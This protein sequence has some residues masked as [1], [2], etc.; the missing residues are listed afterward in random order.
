M[1]FSARFFAFFAN[2][3]VSDPVLGHIMPPKHVQ[4]PF[5]ARLSLSRH[6]PMSDCCGSISISPLWAHFHL[7]RNP[8]PDPE[9]PIDQ[10]PPVLQSAPKTITLPNR[11]QKGHRIRSARMGT[12]FHRTDPFTLAWRVNQVLPNATS[13]ACPQKP[14]RRRDSSPKKM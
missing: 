4:T 1:P 6:P 12:S 8:S 10:T 5:R 13:C 2:F 7:C 14:W 9:S 11:K 3:A